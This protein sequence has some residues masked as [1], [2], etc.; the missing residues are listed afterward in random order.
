MAFEVDLQ[1]EQDETARLQALIDSGTAW[2]LE[3]SVG[4]AA[5]RAIDAGLCVLGPTGQHDYWGGYIPSRFEVKAGI[6]GSIE[7]AN[8]HRA[9]LGLPPIELSDENSTGEIVH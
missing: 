6:K 9:E 7:Y 5:M 4:R 3:G 8:E 2:K 1:D